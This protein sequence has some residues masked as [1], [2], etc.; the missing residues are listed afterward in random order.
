MWVSISIVGLAM[1]S[2]SC[3]AHANISIGV[4]SGNKGLQI[5]YFTGFLIHCK[6][7]VKKCDAGTVIATIF[8]PVQAFY[9]NGVGFS[10]SD[11]CYNSTHDYSNLVYVIFSFILPVRLLPAFRATLSALVALLL[12]ILIIMP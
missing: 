4:F 6:I 11:V 10:M 2:P 9:Y 7:A 3:V 1:C 12:C 8:K 5:A